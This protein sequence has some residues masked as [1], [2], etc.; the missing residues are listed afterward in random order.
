MVEKSR[1]KPGGR[2]S[3]IEDNKNNKLVFSTNRV[4]KIQDKDK[5]EK[6]YINKYV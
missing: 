2:E 5:L 3:K 1:N 6:A 4:T